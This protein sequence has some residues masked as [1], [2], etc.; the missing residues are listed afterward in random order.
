MRIYESTEEYVANFYKSIEKVEFN[1]QTEILGNYLENQI[2]IL[3]Q[4]V[5]MISEHN[6]WEVN[7]QILG[8]DAKLSLVA[9]LIRFDD[10]SEEDII[11]ISENDYTTYFKELCGYTLNT[12]TKHSIVFNVS[13]C[14][15]PSENLYQY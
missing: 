13:W 12:E 3:A 11:R 7:P 10:F 8:I 1:Q 2:N 5:S 6:F 14:T 15:I 4:S 9:E